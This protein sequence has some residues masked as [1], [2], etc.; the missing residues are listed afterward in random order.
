MRLRNETALR[1]SGRASFPV[2]LCL[3]SVLASTVSIPAA[4]QDAAVR[5][6]KPP[7]VTS[8]SNVPSKPSSAPEMNQQS[9]KGASLLVSATATARNKEE[10][11]SR[12]SKE[13]AMSLLEGVLLG[14]DRI[15]PVEYNVLTQIEAAALLWQV[16]QDR[17]LAM[18]KSACETMRE[19]REKDPDKSINSKQRRLRFLA[20][21]KIARLKPELVKDL[22]LNKS[23]DDKSP[24]AMSGDW[25]EEARAIMTIADEQIEKN[26]TL[27]AQLV[28]QTFSLGQV[29]WAVF[30]RK[31]SARDSG[32]SERVAMT[33]IDRLSRS[34]IT[35]IYLLNFRRFVFTPAR[36]AQ[37]KELFFKSLAIRLRRDINPAVS[38]AG[39]NTD[40]VTTQDALR[41]AADYPRWQAEFEGIN[42]ALQEL[43][44]ARSV[45]PDT[46]HN[47]TIPI[48]MMDEIKPGDTK[49]IAEAVPGVERIK[50][51]KARD[52]KYQEMATKAAF[53][54][55]LRLAEE[56]ISKIEDEAIRRDTNLSVYSPFVRKAIN[57]SDWTGATEYASKIVDPLGRTLVLD[58]IAQGMSKSNKDKQSVKE[59]Y[60]FAVYRLRR[61]SPTEDVAKA[62]VI[63]AKS[64]STID[65]EES[66]YAVSWAVYILNRLTRNG[67]LL[68]ESKVGGALAWWVSVPA[69]SLH[70]EVLDLT[71]MI[72]PLFREMAKRDSDIAQ[73]VAHG[74]A[75]QGLYSIA[76]LGIVRALLEKAGNS[77]GGVDQKQASGK[78][79]PRKN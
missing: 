8:S 53:N 29:D 20:F 69:F 41:M 22:A 9:K 67:E 49:E 28:Q 1:T 48:S 65:H 18:L 2:I 75:D 63:L 11:S 27:A 4:Q 42:S 50:E 34:S 70:D 5:A 74:F 24:Q 39:V 3:L 77:K 30:L 43:L 79:A 40:L 45:S 72:G 58:R 61:E 17:A 7:Q 6:A 38:P 10:A 55:D 19:L 57:E 16:D 51:A 21:L 26:P 78:S 59:V 46:R 14:T 12:E 31:L 71:E 25:T 23:N 68:G 64:L 54:S 73:T 33:V 44:K 76:Q 36:S 13:L 60:S 15:T 52:S 56:I 32:L 35:P 66:L 37:L 62:F 47:K